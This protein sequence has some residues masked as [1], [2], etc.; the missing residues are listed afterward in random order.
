MEEIAKY[1]SD[2]T[3]GFAKLYDTPLGDDVELAGSGTLVTVDDL[4]G[5]LTA[6][7][8]LK[9]LPDTGAI[10]LILSKLSDPQLHAPK[11]KVEMLQKIEIGYAKNGAEGPDIGFLVLPALEVGWIQAIK[12][13]YKLSLRRETVLASMPDCRDGVWFLSG[14]AAEQTLEEPAQAGFSKVKV[15]RGDIGAGRVKRHFTAGDFDYIEFEARYVT[16]EPPQS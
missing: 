2:F 5:I 6:G 9:N 16:E 3:I 4:F 12:A 8:V 13:F 1:I 11:I 7:H 14:F 15:F 10:G